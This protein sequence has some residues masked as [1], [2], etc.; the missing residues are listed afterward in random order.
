MDNGHVPPPRAQRIA[1]VCCSQ[2]EGGLIELKSMVVAA[3]DAPWVRQIELNPAVTSANL[4]CLRYLIEDVKVETLNTKSNSYSPLQ[5]AVIWGHTDIVVYL[6]SHGADPMLGQESCVVKMARTRQ[7]RLQEAFEQANDGIEFENVSI[8][9]GRIGPLLTEGFELL[10]VLDGV[11]SYGSFRAWAIRNSGHPLVKRFSKQIMFSERRYELVTIRALVVLGRASLRPAG[12]RASLEARAAEEAAALAR[13]EKTVLD[14][15]VEVG[16]TQVG[17][18]A[19]HDSIAWYYRVK[20]VKELRTAKLSSE[21]IEK[22]LESL[23]F[24]K[25]LPQGDCR[26]FIR[27]ARELEE[28]AKAVESAAPSKAPAKSAPKSK[29]KS[30]YPAASAALLAMS[31]KGKGKS[32]AAKQQPAKSSQP[33]KKEMMDPIG[34][35]FHEDLPDNAFMLI[36]CFF[37]ANEPNNLPSTWIRI[38]NAESNGPPSCLGVCPH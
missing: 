6:L 32:I 12:E 25:I 10:Q 33:K 9:K 21:D 36:T 31:S 5:L 4:A 37:I 16:F 28:P 24:Q 27:W 13:D 35:L 22:S 23:V 1:G 18:K 14:A 8:T 34:L 30:G 26:R 11:G 20:T 7:Q 29:A 15:L 19:I 3:A 38:Q 2:G 17:A